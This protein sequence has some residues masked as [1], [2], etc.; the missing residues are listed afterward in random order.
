MGG[1]PCRLVYNNAGN[2]DPFL[3]RHINV[4]LKRLGLL[5]K[6]SLRRLKK[7]GPSQRCT[8]GFLFLTIVLCVVPTVT[9]ESGVGGRTRD[10]AVL[11]SALV[12]EESCAGGYL[13]LWGETSREKSWQDAGRS[14]EEKVCVDVISF[15]LSMPSCGSIGS[16]PSLALFLALFFFTRCSIIPV[17]LALSLASFFRTSSF[18]PLPSL[19]G[20]PSLLRLV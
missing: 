2:R 20:F 10:G 1:S 3:V 13:W 6:E 8:D 15:G 18:F 19:C 17:D 16:T 5:E 7:W 4:C 14:A 11:H 9:Q 12:L